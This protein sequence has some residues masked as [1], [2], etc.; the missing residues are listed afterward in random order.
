MSTLVIL[1]AGG[2]AA[3]VAESARRAGFLVAGIASQVRPVDGGPFAGVPWLGDPDATGAI[4]S[5]EQ[6]LREGARLQAAVG[7][8]VTRARWLA[9]FGEAAFISVV[10][11]AAVVSVSATIGAGSFIGARAVVQARAAIGRAT[12]V[13]TAAIIEHDCI[14]GDCAHV[15][16]GA[17]L[18]GGVFLGAGTH[19]GAG[20][21]VIPGR[22]VGANATIG[23]GAVVLRDVDAGVTAV[24]VPASAR[25]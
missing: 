12:I 25:A 10:D 1:G 16:P 7:D 3:V 14:V 17:I 6:M 18:C 20:A 23:A 4:P 5:I 8:A 24:G 15:S 22:V 19:V 11:P 13:N 2:H 9:R 21:V